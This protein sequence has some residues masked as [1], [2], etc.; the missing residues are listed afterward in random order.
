MHTEKSHTALPIG[1]SLFFEQKQKV[2]LTGRDDEKL[3]KSS[4]SSLAAFCRGGPF[5]T[6]SNTNLR[7]SPD[8]TRK[9]EGKNGE[10]FHFLW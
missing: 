7:G 8:V 2:N 4:I 6:L 1:I 3:V 10:R 5:T 9:V